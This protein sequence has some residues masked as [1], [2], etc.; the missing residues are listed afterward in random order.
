MH[1]QR[2]ARGSRGA[3]VDAKTLALPRHVLER[4]PFE[5]VVVQPGLPNRHD[6]RQAGALDQVLDRRLLHALVVRMNAHGGPEVFMGLCQAMNGIEFLERRADAQGA[7]HRRLG[8]GVTD[9]GKPLPKAR[10]AE[11]AM[12]VDQHRWIARR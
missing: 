2:Q 3:H 9:L 4:T 10:K 8:H 1:H 12:R 6:A 11:M 5:P 7:V